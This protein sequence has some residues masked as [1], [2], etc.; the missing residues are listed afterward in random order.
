MDFIVYEVSISGI[1]DNALRFPLCPII[2]SWSQM[3]LAYVQTLAP[4]KTIGEGASA[5]RLMVLVRPTRVVVSALVQ[6]CH[7]AHRS[8]VLITYL[9]LCP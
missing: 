6:K 8:H 2:L 5:R 4:L 9:N 7:E 1:P 3:V